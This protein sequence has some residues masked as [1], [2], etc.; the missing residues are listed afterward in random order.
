MDWETNDYSDTY[1]SYNDPPP[2]P[3]IPKEK[4]IMVPPPQ[5]PLQPLP[6]PLDS[7]NMLYVLILF[8]IVVIVFVGNALRNTENLLREIVILLRT[9]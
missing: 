7:Q 5:L 3:R 8:I 1:Y 2:K 9:K 4:K 6:Q